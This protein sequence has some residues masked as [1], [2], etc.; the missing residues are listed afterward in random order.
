MSGV[1]II[2]DELNVRVIISLSWRN[3]KG[4]FSV[5][6][7]MDAAGK[8]VVRVSLAQQPL[9]HGGG[10]VLGGLYSAHSRASGEKHQKGG[11]ETRRK[12]GHL[13]HM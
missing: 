6:V 12:G 11:Q 9:S 10:N 3:A 8:R 13:S 5:L 2:S 1:A 7:Y 4:I